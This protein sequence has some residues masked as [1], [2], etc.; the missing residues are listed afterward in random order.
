[1]KTLF[2]SYID[3]LPFLLDQLL[4]SVS[5]KPTQLTMNLP[6]QGIYLFSENNNHLYIGRTNNIKRRIQNHCRPSSNHNQATFA[7]RIARSETNQHKASYKTEG[8]R[9]QLEDDPIFGP[10]F[11]KAKE[12]IRNMELRFVEINDPILQALFEIYASMILKTPFNDF[13]NH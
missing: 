1:M 11:I 12:R 13:E 6:L 7:F 8:S 2:T 10:A 5:V 9:K 4:K 3:K